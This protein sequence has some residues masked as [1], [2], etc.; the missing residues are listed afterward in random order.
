MR[1]ILLSVFVGLLVVG[2]ATY[3]FVPLSQEKEIC[4]AIEPWGVGEADAA[5]LNR[6][7]GLAWA[8][9]FLYVADTENGEIKKFAQNGSLVARWPG[10]ERPVAIAVMGD[11][12]YVADFLNDRITVLRTD[13]TVITRWGRSG[14][15]DGAFDAPSGIAV[16]RKG[17]V[18]VADFYNHRIQKF[19]GGGDFLLQWGGKGR[20]NGRFRF[21]TEIAVNDQGEVL[22]ADAYN[23]RVQRLTS[24]GDY[25]AQWGGIGFGV[26]GKWPG[27]FRLAKALTVDPR[28]D[29]YVAD[30]FNRR[31]Q[32]FTGGGDLL[33]QLGARGSGD[34][35]LRYPVGVAADPEGRVYVSDFF[36]NRIW[37]VECGQL[38]N[39]AET[40][41][42][43]AVRTNS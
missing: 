13:G 4:S 28:G 5:R 31:I 11:T 25:V 42:V 24:L 21:P 29:V 41:Q 22:V 1:K 38:G 36:E 18:Y 32:K 34:M 6:P 7:M 3:V 30:A 15:G 27:W 20:W 43:Y 33:G 40:G 9:G 16:D 10:F 17:N 14:N 12:V 37:K 23:H 19:S 39:A 2:A 26:P 35:Q 8:D